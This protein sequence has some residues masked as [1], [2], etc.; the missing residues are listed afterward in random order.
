MTDYRSPLWLVGKQ[1][2]AP[3]V[4]STSWGE[5]RVERGN[6]TARHR[7]ILDAVFSVAE[8][9]VLT[10]NGE[11]HVLFDAAAALQLLGTKADS[12]WLRQRLLDLMQVVISTRTPGAHDWPPSRPLLTLVGDT[13][14]D[15][16]REHWQYPALLKKIVLSPAAVAAM[17]EDIQIV[18]DPAIV[19][20][21]LKLEHA[22]SRSLARW[23]MSHKTRQSHSIDNIINVL[24]ANH[25]G[26]RQRRAYVNQ[27]TEDIN[28]LAALGIRITN[29]V[30]TYNR[31]DKG[32]WFQMPSAA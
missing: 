22:I 14:I 19:K 6:P 12:R 10:T 9:A 32:I 18:L 15:A 26:D 29:Q 5:V 11:L 24:G 23:L 16:Q 27:L 30:V 20:K 7:D 4:H 1:P 8:R 13:K 21:I 17:A 31:P 3:R 28:G 25:V 2:S